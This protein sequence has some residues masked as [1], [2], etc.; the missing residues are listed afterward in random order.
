MMLLMLPARIA[1]HIVMMIAMK[2]GIMKIAIGVTTI[3]NAGIMIGQRDQGLHSHVTVD[4]KTSSI[5]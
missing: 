1:T 5:M 2:N 4:W 3:V